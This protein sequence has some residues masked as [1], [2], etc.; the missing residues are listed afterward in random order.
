M[1]LFNYDQRKGG[2]WGK[3]LFDNLHPERGGIGRE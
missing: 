1:T 2:A 3:I